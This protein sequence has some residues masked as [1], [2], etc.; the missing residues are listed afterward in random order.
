VDDKIMED[1][2]LENF[3]PYLNSKFLVKR[4]PEGVEVAELELAQAVD[5]GSTPRHEQFSILFHG[6]SSPKLEQAIYRFEHQEMG[7][8]DLFIVPVKHVQDKIHYEAIF[9]RPL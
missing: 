6:P 9:N 8:F 1:L 3:S 2:K 7:T 5:L 4:D